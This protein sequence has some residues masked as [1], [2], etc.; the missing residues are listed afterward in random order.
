MEMIVNWRRSHHV[1]ALPTDALLA[2]D[3]R[4]GT[5][6]A[7]SGSKPEGGRRP[8]AGG[9]PQGRP[10]A[11]ARPQEGGRPPGAPTE[12]ARPNFDPVARFKGLDK[13][14]DGKVTKDEADERMQSR[15]ETFDT[16]G[17]GGITQEELTAAMAKFRGGGGQR[18]PA[19]DA[20]GN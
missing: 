8:V 12:G 19:G 16:D 9:S 10:D 11:E 3:G 1:I 4:P 17:D 15:F 5:D 7:K 6:E 2:R 18:P 20:G 13:N 14:S